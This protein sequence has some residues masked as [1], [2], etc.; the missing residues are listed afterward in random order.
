MDR[1]TLIATLGA[2]AAAPAARAQPPESA[3][4]QPVPLADAFILLE[5]Y[6]SMDPKDR[7]KWSLAYCALRYKLPAPEAK[8]IIRLENGATRPLMLGPDGVV[9]H[10]P[11]L[12]ELDSQAELEIDGPPF[13]FELE[14]RATIPLT[15]HIAAPAIV[16]ALAQASAG[17]TTLTAQ[18]TSLTCAYFPDGGAGF[19]ALGAGRALPLPSFN[20]KSVGATSYFEPAATP[21]AT[22]VTLAK[23]P[24]RII[25]ARP[26]PTQAA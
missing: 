13:Q 9:T 5:P 2:L 4:P 12:T 10:L 25:L 3:P 23:P 15:A 16:A 19:V 24:S 7:S 14:V 22:E 20:F 18:P 21:G 8:A 11:T 17:L 1:R 6:L 26:P